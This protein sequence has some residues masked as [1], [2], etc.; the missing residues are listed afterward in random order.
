M[1]GGSCQESSVIPLES[2]LQSLEAGVA[3]LQQ[4]L[5]DLEISF[6]SELRIELHQGYTEVRA[7]WLYAGIPRSI[8]AFPEEKPQDCFSRA[9][10][11]SFPAH[12]TK[13]KILL[14]CENRV[15]EETEHFWP[16]FKDI[17]LEM[18]PAQ[19]AVEVRF[20]VEGYPDKGWVVTGT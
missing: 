2:R 3:E 4:K 8:L 13:F 5:N 19:G 14:V 1:T 20:I 6:L 10:S 7:P 11:N 18:L 16:R 9:W 15:Y 12:G 17:L